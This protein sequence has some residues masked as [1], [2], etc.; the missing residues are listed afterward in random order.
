MNYRTETD[1]QVRKNGSE[2]KST[3]IVKDVEKPKK[4]P[5]IDDFVII[6]GA[7]KSGT[8]TLFRYLRSHPEIAG[9]KRKEPSFFSS[10][11]RWNLGRDY[12][13][14][15]WPRFD[16]ARHRYALEASPEYTKAPYVTNVARR[17]RAFGA[18]FRFIYILR[19]PVDRVESHIIHNI[20]MGRAD[21][22][23]GFDHRLFQRAID[24][25]RYAYQLDAF[26][27]DFDDA[28]I[29][30]LDFDD[31]KSNPVRVMERCVGFLGIDRGFEFPYV[32]PA[33][34]RKAANMADT[35]RLRPEDRARIVGLLR[36]DVLRLRDAYGFDVSGWKIL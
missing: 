4:P 28:Q 7:M 15:L 12:Y 18:R 23:I 35:F 27:Q 21:L 3:D 33:N 20:G 5:K 26:R 13:L 24:V 22:G 29:L 25:S 8:T 2:T 17:M 6:L 31:L 11:R 14:K 9:C 16:P 34:V 32:A 19:D 10:N 36:P 30:L 1:R